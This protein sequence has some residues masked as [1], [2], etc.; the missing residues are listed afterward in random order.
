[1]ISDNAGNRDTL[2]EIPVGSGT[3]LTHT[4]QGVIGRTYTLDIKNE[5]KDYT[6]ISTIPTPVILDSIFIQVNPP[7][8]PAPG[9]PPM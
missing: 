6:A 9:G 8:F 1:V 4:I 7:N 3:Y 2:T 5:G